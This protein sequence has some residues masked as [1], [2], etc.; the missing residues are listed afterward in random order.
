MV[1]SVLDGGGRK[2]KSTFVR[3]LHKSFAAAFTIDLQI[4][5]LWHWTIVIRVIDASA[6]EQI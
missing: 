6:E 5:A 2:R 4:Y 1:Q 3:S